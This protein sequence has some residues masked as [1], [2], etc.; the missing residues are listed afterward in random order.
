MKNLC[1]TPVSPST[2]VL[3]Y[4]RCPAK[5]IKVTTFEACSHISSAVAISA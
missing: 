5:S 3:K 2:V 4:F 1:Y